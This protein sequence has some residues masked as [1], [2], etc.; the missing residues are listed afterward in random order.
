METQI[1]DNIITGTIDNVTNFLLRTYV[2]SH[3]NN[4]DEDKYGYIGLSALN[5]IKFTKQKNG[6]HYSFWAGVSGCNWNAVDAYSGNHMLSNVREDI[7]TLDLSQLMSVW[8][9]D[10]IIYSRKQK[11]QWS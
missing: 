2:L 8:H 11:V 1:K 10:E 9:T 5:G 6:E 7:I 4:I 3:F